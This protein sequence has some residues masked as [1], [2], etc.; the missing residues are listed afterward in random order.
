MITARIQDI[1]DQPSALSAKLFFSTTH[2]ADNNPGCISPRASEAAHSFHH[3]YCHLKND[4]KGHS[5]PFLAL[6]SWHS[7][8]T[9]TSS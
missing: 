2:R 1:D 9:N 6:T 8:L 7:C 4:L 5:L 3:S